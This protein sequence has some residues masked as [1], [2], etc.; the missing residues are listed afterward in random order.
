MM[1]PEDTV[2]RF[3]ACWNSGDKES[4]YAM[5][6]AEIVWHNIPMEPIV[7]LTAMREVVAGFM[8]RVESC[9][10]EIHAIAANGNIV[11]TER[12]DAFVL[13]D[14]SKAALPVMG[15]FKIDD[16]GLIQQWRDYFDM[17]HF[18]RAFGLDAS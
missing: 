12:T 9:E 4:M 14:G 8:A 1:T 16:E 6:V 18:T 5:C 3:V 13:T 2:R 10:W 7:G 11:L 15:T 17:G